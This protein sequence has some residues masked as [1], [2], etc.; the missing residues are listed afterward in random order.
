MPGTRASTNRRVII[1]D[2]GESDDSSEYAEDYHDHESY[3]AL[4]DETSRMSEEDGFAKPS[5]RRTGL[6]EFVIAPRRGDSE[7]TFFIC[8]LYAHG[9]ANSICRG[10]VLLRLFLCF[11]PPRGR[12]AL[13]HFVWRLCFRAAIFEGLDVGW[14]FMSCFCWRGASAWGEVPFADRLGCAA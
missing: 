8:Q 13:A 1:P 11:R 14:P 2:A 12:Q 7:S 6:D 9:E 3:R 5:G 10:Q 4:V